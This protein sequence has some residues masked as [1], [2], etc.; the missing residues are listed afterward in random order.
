MNVL[1]LTK[2]FTLL[3]AF[4]ILIVSC[5]KVA[6]V[7]EDVNEGQVNFS[8]E[9]IQNVLL[10]RSTKTQEGLLLDCFTIIFPFTMVDTEME[11]YEVINLDEYVAL[12]DGENDPSIIDFEYPLTI[13]NEDDTQVSIEDGLRLV[14]R[15]AN[16]L[17]NG[18]EEQV[19]P[20]YLI[21]ES[22]SCL[23][24]VYP[25]AV[26]A[27]GGETV[28]YE[29]E[30]SYLVALSEEPLTFVFPVNLVNPEGETIVTNSVGELVEALIDCNGLESGTAWS[31]WGATGFEDLG[32]F[33]IAYPFNVTLDNGSVVEINDHETFC[34]LLLQGNMSGFVFPMTLIGPN[35]E[36]II[37]TEKEI[38]ILQLDCLTRILGTLL[39]GDIEEEGD[40][41]SLLIGAIEIQSFEIESCYEIQ[42][43]ISIERVDFGGNILEEKVL[44]DFAQL[45]ALYYTGEAYANIY[46]VVFP[47]SVT[48]VST[49][50]EIVFNNS[51]EVIEFNLECRN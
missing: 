16:C 45:D 9:F 24:L 29:D 36:I 42:F 34:D 35:G 39:G 23:T 26:S 22:N 51:Q 41:F 27:L 3:F 19:F 33:N 46:N 15:F 5:S 32:C 43:P 37:N 14:M 47:V 4:S 1:R 13:Q 48:I 18:W 31:D 21:N 38:T 20:A 40:L 7:I 30:T 50:E 12:F 6:E 10:S 11:R 49:E 17:P 28:M 44:E 8:E 2:I 25:V